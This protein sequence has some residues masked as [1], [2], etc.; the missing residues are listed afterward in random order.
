MENPTKTGIS[1]KDFL[2][3]EKG[4]RLIAVLSGDVDK[5]GKLPSKEVGW[6]YSLKV[7][8]LDAMQMLSCGHFCDLTIDKAIEKNTPEEIVTLFTE[9]LFDDDASKIFGPDGDEVYEGL[10][11]AF[12]YWRTDESGELIDFD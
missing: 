3:S 5:L 10:E 9:W 1:L 12:R 7:N 2:H 6:E 11:G 4:Q 8:L